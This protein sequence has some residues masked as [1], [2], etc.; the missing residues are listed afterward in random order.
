MTD[1]LER[2]K[3]N[4]RTDG[5]RHRFAS[6]RQKGGIGKENEHTKF[7]ILNLRISEFEYPMCY[8][9]FQVED[10]KI[11]TF[12]QRKASYPDF[13][14]SPAFIYYFY[15]YEFHIEFNSQIHGNVLHGNVIILNG[16]L[17]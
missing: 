15:F 4:N 1:G 3:N 12:E 14:P 17:R 8:V 6:A 2:K 16:D 10:L 5:V 7:G 13:S 11:Q 9:E